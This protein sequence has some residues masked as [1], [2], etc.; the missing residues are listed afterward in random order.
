MRAQPHGFSTLDFGSKFTIFRRDDQT[1]SYN[2]FDDPLY[3]IIIALLLVE[4]T[5]S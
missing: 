5:G 4:D 3:T 1:L 2:R